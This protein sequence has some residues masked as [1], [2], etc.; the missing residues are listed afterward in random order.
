MVDM[1]Y[2]NIE[3]LT[4]AEFNGEE[5]VRY[6]LTFSFVSLAH[7]DLTIKFAFSSYFYIILYLLIGVLSIGIMIMFALFHRLVARPKNG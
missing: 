5:K 1:D 4:E 2:G 7:K 6:N 3:K